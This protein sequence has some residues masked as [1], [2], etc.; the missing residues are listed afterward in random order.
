MIDEPSTIQQLIDHAPLTTQQL[1]REISLLRELFFGEVTN[2][3]DAIKVAHEDAVRVPTE[4]QKAIVA[5]R[6]LQDEKIASLE[7]IHEE[8]FIGIQ[9]RFSERDMRIEQ[10]SKDS[11]IAVDA[12]LQAAEKAVAKSEVATLKQIDQQGDLI[13]QNT[14]AYDDKIG[15]VKDRL[16]RIEG[17]AAGSLGQKTSTQTSSMNMASI[18]SIVIGAVVGLGGL[19][20]TVVAF[21]SK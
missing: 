9:Q 17:I 7:K 8:K 11:R 12:A 3:K 5:L 10:A 1:L 16:T 19:I 4:I 21:F 13:S 14:K 2:I 20:L 15:D 18:V 6:E